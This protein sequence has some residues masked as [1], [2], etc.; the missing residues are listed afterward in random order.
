MD[1]ASTERA[2]SLRKIDDDVSTAVDG[3]FG[4]EAAFTSLVFTPTETLEFDQ[5]YAIDVSTD[6]LPA[7]AKGQ[8]REAFTSRFEVAPY[9]AVA[10]IY[11]VEGAAGVS[12]DTSVSIR[13]NTTVSQTLALQHITI[14]PAL[15]ATTVYSY[16][17]L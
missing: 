2:F 8:L 7:G 4:W 11:P 10:N 9:P 12:P 17:S 3:E 5:S 14:T 1:L 6:A 13:F 16:Y 15:T